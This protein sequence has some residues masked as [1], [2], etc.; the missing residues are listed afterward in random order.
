[1]V[2]VKQAKALVKQNI[3]P[4]SPVT[5]KLQDAVDQ[6]LAENIISR[7]DIPPFNQSS[8]D[9]YA[10]RYS[11]WKSHAKLAV[12]DKIPAGHP[13]D[14]TIGPGNAARIFTGAAVPVGADTVIM[15]EKTKMESGSLLILDDTLTP[16]THVRP[17]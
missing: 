16:G 14:K 4:L 11:D 9:G 13:A 17:K 10:F 15:Q 12:T 8:M 7:F 2:T 5:V 6:V 1:M 3:L